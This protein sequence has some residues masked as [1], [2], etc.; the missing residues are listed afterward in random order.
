MKQLLTLLCAA[1]VSATTANAQ[2]VYGYSPATAE[3]TY[4][5]ITDGTVIY[6]GAEADEGHKGENVESILLTA[7]GIKTELSEVTGYS[8]GF[9]YPFGGKTYS[10]FAVSP[11]GWVAF[12]GNSAFQVDP[13]VGNAFYTSQTNI[14]AAGSASQR[15]VAG[16]DETQISYKTIGEGENAVLIVQYKNLGVR[17]AYFGNCLPIDMQLRF[18]AKGDISIIYNDLASLT[19]IEATEET[20]GKD[21]FD[22][23]YTM[24][25]VCQDGKI[26]YIEGDLSEYTIMHRN[27]G[28]LT[29]PT[30]TTPDGFTITFK[31]P[32]VC[33]TP[34]DGP[35]D[36]V[37]TSTSTT[38]EGS[39]TGSATA[40]SYLIVSSDEEITWTP[41]NGTYYNVDDV[42]ED[43]ISVVKFGSDTSFTIEELDGGKKIYYAVYACSAYGI[44]GPKYNTL[45]VLNGVIATKPAMPSVT[46]GATGDDYTTLNI[47]ANTAG[48]DVIV[49]ITDYCLRDVYGDHGLFGALTAESKEGDVLDVPADWAPIPIFG[50]M[51]EPT[52]GGKVIYVGPAKELI[53]SEL[54]NST[55]YFIGVYSRDEEGNIST[56]VAYNA[57]YTTIYAPYSGDS[58]QF[59]RYNLPAGW[60]TCDGTA[61]N[62]TAF[63]VEAT[64]DTPES[65]QMMQIRAQIKKGSADGFTAWLTTSPIHVN[66]HNLMAKFDF[67]LEECETRFS[68]EPYK[69]W[70]ENDYITLSVST[71]NGTTW[72]ALT[73]YTRYSHPTQEE[74][75]SYISI[76]ADLDDYYDQTVLIKFEMLTH[77]VAMFGFHIYIDRFSVLPAIIHTVPEFT[78]QSVT[79]NSATLTWTQ[80]ET[81]NYEL[82][83]KAIDDDD[84]QYVTVEDA[85]SYTITDLTTLTEYEVGVRGIIEEDSYTE[86]STPLTITTLDW[87]A[88]D[89][90]E[91]L[92]SDLTNYVTDGVV[93]LSW[94]TTEEMESYE[95]QYRVSSETT[96]TTVSSDTAELTLTDLAPETRYIWKVKAFCSHDRETE[97]S[98]QANF[99]TPAKSAL[100]LIISDRDNDVEVYTI[101]GAKVNP[102]NLTPG[103]YIVKKNGKYIKTR[104]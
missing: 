28:P 34:T 49:V 83:Y 30:A 52:N 99:T 41:E 6:N 46:V 38:I 31:Y 20:E 78:A 95:I 14:T 75:H 103:L 42:I 36:F 63:R 55:L 32:L 84:Y 50:E 79:H 94:S 88:V 26:T 15:G 74:L 35:S 3:G 40:D 101:T 37:L 104:L 73:E 92:E 7:D 39:F 33:A 44:D 71:D 11:S 48:D 76:E 62:E 13:S 9:D 72:T 66:E 16:L 54:N 29:I 77:T 82:R 87:P 21:G 86:W 10:S 56:D 45:N 98:A 57:A 22:N 43:K 102:D 17:G 27:R 1:A 19:P 93:K 97:Y 18:S 61:A 67:R 85:N 24:T 89:A 53:I 80:S 70:K 25:G 68:H 59:P 5:A 64:G 8:I 60:A 81:N 91:N 4:D 65:T 90:P 96:W 47:T 69:E 2:A 12:G 58:D 23:I 51:P 100:E